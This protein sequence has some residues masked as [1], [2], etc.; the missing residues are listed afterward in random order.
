MSKNPAEDRG[1]KVGEAPEILKQ[2]DKD[3]HTRIQAEKFRKQS[4]PAAEGPREII[5]EIPDIVESIS[6]LVDD[7]L[8][9]PLFQSNAG[10]VERGV[11]DNMTD[12]RSV[13]KIDALLRSTKVSAIIASV[14]L[15]S[16]CLRSCSR[17]SPVFAILYGIL[18]ADALR[19]ASNCYIKNYIALAMKGLGSDGNPAKIGAAVFQWWVG[20]FF[21]FWLNAKVLPTGNLNIIFIEYDKC[22]LN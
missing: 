14:F 6:K 19:M 20:F 3:D 12:L 15:F 2:R 1:Y 8:F 4:A 10:V 21:S 16:L 22:L 5:N 13:R 9:E 17:A 7:N 11:S 18:S